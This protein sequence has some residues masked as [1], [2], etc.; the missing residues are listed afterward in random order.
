MFKRMSTPI[1][2]SII[3]LFTGCAAKDTGNKSTAVDITN[4][5]SSIGAV[6]ENTADFETQSFKYTVTLTNNDTTDITIVS[7]SPVLSEKF[8]ERVSN[9]DTLIQVNKTIL[10]G[11]SL[12]INGEIIFNAKGLTK[13]QIVTL[14]PFVKEIKIIE[15][16][17]IKKSF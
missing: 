2:I 5:G 15:E 16:R 17:T 12:D 7:V 3:L 6:G 8:L 14:D 10:Q 13:E 9:K 11:N 4:I 1:L